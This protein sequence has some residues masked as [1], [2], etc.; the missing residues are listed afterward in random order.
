MVR[1]D[2]DEDLAGELA[3]KHAFRG[4]DAIHLAAALD[5]S[6]VG[7]AGTWLFSSF[8]SRLNS[9]AREE[10]LEVLEP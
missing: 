4:F 8:D 3:F 10:G 2:L 9:A 1:L 7:P 6:R 5:A